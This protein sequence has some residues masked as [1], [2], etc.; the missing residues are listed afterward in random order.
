[1]NPTVNHHLVEAL[2]KI[3]N[4][5]D[6]LLPWGEGSDFPWGDPDF[7]RRTLAEHLDN[8]NGAA[9]RSV[10]ER[11]L[12]LDWLWDKLGLQ[13][14]MHVYDITCGPGLYAVELARRGC[15][16]T[17]IDINPAAIAHANT[18]AKQAGVAER[19]TFIELDVRNLPDYEAE[20]DVALFM[21][22]QLA[23]YSR[24]EAQMLLTK[25]GQSLKVGGRICLELL[26][27]DNV[28]KEDS[29]WW[30]TDDNG[31][32][33]DTPFLHMG[34]RVWDDEEE[35]A[36]E[37]YFILHLESGELKRYTL[38]DQT[39]AV[40]TMSWMLAQAGFSAVNHFPDW[41]GL[42]LYDAREWVVYTAVKV[43]D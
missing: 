7:G 5:T 30:F 32:W 43:E 4:R 33:G 25:I 41:D 29:S 11:Q 37:R 27:Q 9:S 3:Y 12:Q 31:L 21:Y 39:Y 13:P 19:C 2:W 23:V 14:G 34:E 35:A 16:V 20:F 40:E 10:K 38:Y 24:E 15:T 36:V 26:N 8:S 1:M 17:G 28:D 22:E 42:P 6:E 18:L